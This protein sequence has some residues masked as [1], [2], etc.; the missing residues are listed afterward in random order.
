[1]PRNNFKQ[2]YPCARPARPRPRTLESEC[3]DQGALQPLTYAL[4]CARRG[5]SA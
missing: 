2:P 4:R 5:A 1:M 3:R